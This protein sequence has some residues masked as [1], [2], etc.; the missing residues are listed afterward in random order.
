MRVLLTGGAG[1]IGSHTAVALLDAGHEIIITDNLSNSNIGS[2]E[3]IRMITGKDFK[4]YKADVCNKEE[5]SKVFAE[6]EID[7]VI[8]LAG[9]KAVGESVKK[10]LNYYGNNLRS[11]ITLLEVIEEQGVENVLFSS[12]ATVYGVENKPPYTE[13]MERGSCSNPY[14]Y[15][16]MMSEQILQDAAIA[17]TKLSVTLLRYFNPIGAHESGFIGENPNGVPNNLMPYITQV[18]IG[19]REKL[20]IYG[21]DYRTADGTCRR[22]YI[23]VMDLADGHLRAIEHGVGDAGVHIYN[24][25]TGEPISVLEIV[26]TFE[27]VNGTK[28]P[29]EIGAR[30][31]GD[32]DEFWADATKASRE[33]GWKAKRNLEDMCRDSWNWQVNNPNGY[34]K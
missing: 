2:I 18:A 6:N 11:T 20:T 34:D 33:L 9:L 10:P 28:I 22:D 14:S 32:L 5:L 17:N 30:R 25:G 7:A 29:C 15:T 31:E 8:H 21:D 24:L 12:S 3:R 16:K 19:R 27:R 4:F 1:Y 23:H 26:E 13:E